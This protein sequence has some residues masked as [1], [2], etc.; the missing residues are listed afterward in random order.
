MGYLIQAEGYGRRGERCGAESIDATCYKATIIMIIRALD[1]F[2]RPADI[3]MHIEN[4]WIVG[5]LIRFEQTDKSMKSQLELCS[6]IQVVAVC[7][8]AGMCGKDPGSRRYTAQETALFTAF[9]EVNSF[10]SSAVRCSLVISQQGTWNRSH[11]PPHLLQPVISLAAWTP[12][13]FVTSYLGHSENKSSLNLH[14]SSKF[15]HIGA[16]AHTADTP[17]KLISVLRM[18]LDT[19]AL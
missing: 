10:F 14:R 4:G 11:H 9:S 12:T 3:T 6:C 19:Q 1:C 16:K 2:T 5:N 13:H 7:F 17:A 8:L 18:I 15:Q